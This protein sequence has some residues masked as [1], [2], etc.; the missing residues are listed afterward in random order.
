MKDEL[1]PDVALNLAEKL[2]EKLIEKEVA[3]QRTFAIL[4]YFDAGKTTSCKKFLP[5]A[6]AVDPSGTLRAQTSCARIALSVP[7]R[8]TR[9]CPVNQFGT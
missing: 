7:A 8:S 6:V 1:L 2:I 5:S 4:S 3:R 9:T